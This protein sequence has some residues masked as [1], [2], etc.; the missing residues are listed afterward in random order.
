MVL[1]KID[2]SLRILILRD[3][4]HL[5]F[6]ELFLGSRKVQISTILEAE[7]AVASRCGSY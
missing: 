3:R 2:Y 5:L 7:A 4:G 6:S 1:H